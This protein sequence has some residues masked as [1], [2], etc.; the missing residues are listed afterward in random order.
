M[1]TQFQRLFHIENSIRKAVIFDLDGTLY[2]SGP[3]KQK[4]AWRFLRTYAMHPRQGIQVARA[5]SAYRKAH[6]QLRVL[7]TQDPDLRHAQLQIA[8]DRTRIPLPQLES[9]VQRWMEEE[10]LSLLEDLTKPGLVPL[11]YQLNAAG[12]ALG[13]VSDYAALEKLQYMGIDHFLTSSSV[14][15]TKM[16]TK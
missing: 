5:L 11:L 6:E 15:R 8:S 1:R 13:V 4:M 2:E 14:H 7:K 12:F 16:S 10:P 3:L 9:W